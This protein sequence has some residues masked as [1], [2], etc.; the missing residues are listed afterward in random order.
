M[1]TQFLD[2]PTFQKY[3]NAYAEVIAPINK[4]IDQLRSSVEAAK[5]GWQG[6]AYVAFS[7]FATTLEEQ[8]SQV[9]KDLGLVSDA[10]NT[11]EH[12]VANSDHET[13]TGFTSLAK[14]YS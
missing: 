6:D 12:T 14:S 4:T 1:A 11:G 5:S 13:S 10:L 9:N 7:S 2:F 8:I 3:A